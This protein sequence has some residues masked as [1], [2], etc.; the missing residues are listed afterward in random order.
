MCIERENEPKM[1]LFHVH[2]RRMGVLVIEQRKID[3][4]FHRHHHRRLL[5]Q[6]QCPCGCSRMCMLLVDTRLEGHS[7]MWVVV[8]RGGERDQR[9][10]HRYRADGTQEVRHQQRQ[11]LHQ[12]YDSRIHTVPLAYFLGHK[13][14]Y[15]RNTCTDVKK[16]SDNWVAVV[17][18]DGTEDAER[19]W[20]LRQRQ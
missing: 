4:L 9:R 15:R 8:V 18:D 17:K 2:A 7:H 12:G 11:Q 10:H 1:M 19:V 3:V 20:V 14:Q 16:V 13:G 6:E 5:E